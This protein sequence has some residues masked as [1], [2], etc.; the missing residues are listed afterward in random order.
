MV[1]RIQSFFLFCT[2]IV[3]GLLFFMPV[4]SIIV[5]DNFTFEFYT[6]KVMQAGNPPV[7]IAWNW[8]SLILNAII[9]ILAFLTIF[10]HRKKSKTVKPTLLLQFRLCIVNIIFMSGLLILM[11]LQLRQRTGE[12]RGEWFAHLGFIFPLIGIIFTW[13][14]IRGLV[15]DVALLKSFDRIR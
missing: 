7:F 10:I 2:M 13:L 14:A 4:A 5:P 9:T 6:T 3:T 1:L 8:M 15:K 12:I 11:W